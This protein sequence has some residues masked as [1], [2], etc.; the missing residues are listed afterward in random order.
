MIVCENAARCT[1][2]RRDNLFSERT[3]T[4]E[5]SHPLPRAVAFNLRSS[6]VTALSL[7]SRNSHT[8]PLHTGVAPSPR[9][10]V[11]LYSRRQLLLTEIARRGVARGRATLSLGESLTP[12]RLLQAESAQ[13]PRSGECNSPERGEHDSRVRGEHDSPRKEMKLSPRESRVRT[14][15]RSC[16]VA[17]AAAAALHPRGTVALSGSMTSPHGLVVISPRGRVPLFCA[18]ECMLSSR[19]VVLFS[20]LGAVARSLC[21]SE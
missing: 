1:R 5:I 16:C 18:R 4:V 3:S 11:A 10:V 9:V 14:L 15:R 2:R 13:L 21:E 6:A 19:R 12:A 8:L 17:A 20:T 7:P